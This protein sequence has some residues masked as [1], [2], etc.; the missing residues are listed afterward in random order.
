MVDFCNS[1]AR[2]PGYISTQVYSRYEVS[3]EADRRMFDG[4]GGRSVRYHP[5]P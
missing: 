4:V 2:A 3:D 1:R 5:E